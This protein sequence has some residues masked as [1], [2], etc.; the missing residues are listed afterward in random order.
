MVFKRVPLDVKCWMELSFKPVHIYLFNAKSQILCFY[1]KK[2][3]KMKGCTPGM[4]LLANG[5]S[6]WL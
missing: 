4:A 3:R 1:L 5:I 6:N 2:L